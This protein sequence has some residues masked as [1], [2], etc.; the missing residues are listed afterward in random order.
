G[1]ADGEHLPGGHGR[2]QRAL[3]LHGD[4]PRDGRRVDPDPKRRAAARH[5]AARALPRAGPRAG[6]PLAR[7]GRR[8]LA[9]RPSPAPRPSRRAPTA[10]ARA[11]HPYPARA[12]AGR[13]PTA[14]PPPPSRS[15]YHQSR[16]VTWTATL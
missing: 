8:E 1:P 12:S 16:R 4:A 13:S 7:A 10:R 9:H 15:K 6:P 2:R 5:L 11:P 14:R 3:A